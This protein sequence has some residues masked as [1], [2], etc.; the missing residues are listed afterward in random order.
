MNHVKKIFN[1]DYR[2]RKAVALINRYEWLLKALGAKEVVLLNNIR[3]DYYNAYGHYPDLRHPKD[4]NEKLLWMA[5]YW[6]NP[7]KARCADKYR[8]REYVTKDC[9]LPEELLVPLHGVWNRV[10]DIDFQ[11]FPDK[12]VLKCNHGCGYNIIVPDKSQ[13]DIERAK[14]QLTLWLKEDYAGN[15]SEIHYK[16]IHPHVVMCEEYLESESGRMSMTDYKVFC[17]NGKPSFVFICYDRDEHGKAHYATYSFEWKQKY[18]TKGELQSCFTA[19]QSLKE[20]YN[21]AEALSRPFPFVRVD[22]YEVNGKPLLGEMTFTPY[23]NI[24]SYFKD[25]ILLHYGELLCL[26]NKKTFGR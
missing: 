8:C 12:F 10:E 19:P 5:Y 3:K 4:L 23:G 2:E 22:F 15:A 20:M 25:D 13:F 11:T 26:P 7:M 21:Y 6:R 17:F 16:D 14:A 9:G 18:Y 24:M 1:S